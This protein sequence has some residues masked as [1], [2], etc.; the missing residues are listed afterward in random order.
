MLRLRCIAIAIVGVLLTIGPQAV[1]AREGPTLVF[2]AASLTGV[3]QQAIEV[4]EAET[5]RRVVPSFAASSALAQQIVSGAPARIFLSANVRWMDHVEQAGLIRPETRIDL[6]GNRLVLVAPA[7]GNASAVLGDLSALPNHLGDGRL[8][9]GDPAHVP[10]GLYT[11]QALEQLGLWSAVESRLAPMADVRRALFLVER[12]EAPFGIV[13]AT[14][15]AASDGVEMVAA[16]PEDAHSPIV[17]PAALLA[18]PE[19]PVAVAFFDFVQGPTASCIFDRAGFSV[20][21]RDVVAV[22]CGE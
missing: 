11:R 13:Y 15:A 4:F 7:D 5:G 22:A 1:S 8:A 21:G 17:Y 12:G 20:L 18:G 6:L 19:D 10:A 2:A 3:L 16:L 9:I 14:D